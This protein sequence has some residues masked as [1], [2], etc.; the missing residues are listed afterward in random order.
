MEKD[1]PK[2]ATPARVFPGGADRA[3]AFPVM[4]KA[5]VAFVDSPMSAYAAINAHIVNTSDD[6]REQLNEGVEFSFSYGGIRHDVTLTRE[7]D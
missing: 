5:I 3:Q 7:E 2:K 6:E 1:S 4:V